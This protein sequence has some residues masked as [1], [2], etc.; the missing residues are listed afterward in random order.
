MDLIETIK[1]VTKS[2][3]DIISILNNEN[4]ENKYYSFM[5]WIDSNNEGYI[6]LNYTLFLFYIIVI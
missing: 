6:S 1:L 2:H 5:H 3:E 4:N